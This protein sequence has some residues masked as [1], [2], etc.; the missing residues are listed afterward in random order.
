MG[1]PP[2]CKPECT[3]NSECSS[4]LVC[5]RQKCQNPCLGSCGILA[6]CN[7]INHTPI[8]SCPD[9]YT[10]DP[11]TMCNIKPEKRKKII[12][13]SYKIFTFHLNLQ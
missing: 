7:V 12:D 2:N 9:G 1:S 6:T 10:G 11:F 13:N 5:M 4:N 3:I 8:C